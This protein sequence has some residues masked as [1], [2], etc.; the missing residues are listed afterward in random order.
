[1]DSVYNDGDL[2]Y[3]L[4]F[5]A[6]ETTMLE[7][8]GTDRQIFKKSQLMDNGDFK[9]LFITPSTQDDGTFGIKYQDLLFVSA[10]TGEG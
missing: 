3:V 6:G 5:N 7:A 4:D 1:M 8:S 9:F 10:S 2:D